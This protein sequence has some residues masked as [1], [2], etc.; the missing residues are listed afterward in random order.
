[1]RLSLANGALS[2]TDYFEPLDGIPG[3]ANYADQGSGGAILTAPFLDGSYTVPSFLVG[4]GGDGNVY[5][6]AANGAVTLGGYNGSTNADTLTVTG[7]LPHGAATAAAA[8]NGTVYYAAS[9]DSVKAFNILSRGALTSQSS[10]VMGSGG[11]TP[12]VSAS[13][14]GNAILWLVDTTASGGPVLHAYDATNL[15]TELYNSS[16]RGGDAIGPASAHAVPVVANGNVYVGT[17]SGVLI[18]GATSGH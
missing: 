7:A 10:S 9:S 6:M 3:S 13:G 8:L 15:A 4:A 18:Y 17:R 11:A 16:A 2:V 14:T 12:V 5:M 1:V